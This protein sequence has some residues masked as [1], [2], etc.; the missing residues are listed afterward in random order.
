MLIRWREY[1]HAYVIDCV[2]DCVNPN[3]NRVSIPLQPMVVGAIVGVAQ[4]IKWL[5][6]LMIIF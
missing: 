2:H 3:A 5:P 1:V 6:E 4:M